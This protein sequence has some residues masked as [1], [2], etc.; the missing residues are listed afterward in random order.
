MYEIDYGSRFGRDVK[1][2]T[3]RHWDIDSL[4][5]AIT[6]L[7]R[8]DEIALSPRYKDHALTGSRQGYHAIHIDSAPNPPKDKW[9]L[10]YK[11]IGGKIILV[12]T[13]THEEVYGK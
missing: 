7:M 2:C 4:K 8:S 1:N 11:V 3:K 12:R 9:V 13:G 5:K 10:I 6:D